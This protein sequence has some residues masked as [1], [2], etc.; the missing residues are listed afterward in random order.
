MIKNNKELKDALSNLTALSED[1]AQ[2]CLSQKY[3]RIKE[4]EDILH[5]YGYPVRTG[6]TKLA[7]EILNKINH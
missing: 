7:C 4:L 5:Q 2:Y 1:I 3:G 6:V